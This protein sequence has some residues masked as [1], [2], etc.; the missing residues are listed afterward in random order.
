ML[1]ALNHIFI[2]N[3]CMY[4]HVA[5]WGIMSDFYLLLDFFFFFFYLMSHVNFNFSFLS[6]GTFLLIC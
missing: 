4:R 3:V 5:F 1:I 6:L 2:Y